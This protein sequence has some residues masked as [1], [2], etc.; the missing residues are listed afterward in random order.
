MTLVARMSLFF[1]TFGR[2]T[3]LTPTLTQGEREPEKACEITAYGSF[4]GT[5]INV[6]VSYLWVAGVTEFRNPGQ[7]RLAPI[8]KLFTTGFRMTRSARTNAFVRP[9]APDGPPDSRDC[10]PVVPMAWARIALVLRELGRWAT[11]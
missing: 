5:G 8:R 7:L 11:R 9:S 3:T 2:E 1:K 4:N 6:P 10:R